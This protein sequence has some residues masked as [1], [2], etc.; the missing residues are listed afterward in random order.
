MAL[1]NCPTDVASVYLYF[2]KEALAYNLM[3]ALN[4]MAV[5]DHVF[6]RMDGDDAEQFSRCL[7]KALDNAAAEYTANEWAI[8]GDPRINWQAN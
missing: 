2:S 3:E 1:T 6:H 5:A 4:R 8:L 7:M